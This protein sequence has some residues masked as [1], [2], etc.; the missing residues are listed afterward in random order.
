MDSNGREVA[1]AQKLVEFGGSECALDEDDDLVELEFIEQFIEFAVLLLLVEFD[2]VL[3]KAVE[4]KLG[5]IINV[6]FERVLHKLLADRADL[7]GECCA[8]HHNLLLCRSG[9][10]DLLN[11]AAHVYISH[12]HLGRHGD[13]PNSFIPT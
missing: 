4:G 11:V 6:D 5:L 7:L 2:V 3:L 8:E 1:L 9:A 12:Q 13:G 10:E